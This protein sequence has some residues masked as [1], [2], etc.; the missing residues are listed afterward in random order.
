[1]SYGSNMDKTRMHS[2]VGAYDERIFAFLPNYDLD[3]SKI[4]SGKMSKTFVVFF[5][6]RRI[7]I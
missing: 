4:K 5:K 6:K 7:P 3:F 1:M 2:R